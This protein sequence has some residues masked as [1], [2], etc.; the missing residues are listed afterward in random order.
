M[1]VSRA[2]DLHQEPVIFLRVMLG[3]L[4]VN[5][6]YLGFDINISEDNRILTTHSGERWEILEKIHCSYEIAEKGT[7][8]AAVR[9]WGNTGEASR[10]GQS[11]MKSY[12]KRRDE[13]PL[14]EVEFL[15]KVQGLPGVIQLLHHEQVRVMGELDMTA[16]VP[17]RP[18]IELVRHRL[19][20]SPRGREL[21][22][23]FLK[24]GV[25]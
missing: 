16:R 1:Q 15:E 2:F 24:C 10:G 11:V 23:V 25:L 14:A 22:S 7:F 5:R 9:A 17:G 13:N 20:L 12:W 19:I 6:A 21:T 4:Y 3:L 8:V 18:R